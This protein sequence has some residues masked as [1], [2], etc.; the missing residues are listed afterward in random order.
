MCQRVATLHKYIFMNLPTIGVGAPKLDCMGCDF[1]IVI[2][3]YIIVRGDVW[4]LRR[5]LS[6]FTHKKLWGKPKI[7]TLVLVAIKNKFPDSSPT[8]SINLG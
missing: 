7:I 3:S 4:T 5:R 6:S 2:V 8:F 1:R